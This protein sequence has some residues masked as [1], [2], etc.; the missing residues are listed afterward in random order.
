MIVGGAAREK[1]NETLTS[2]T[3]V[4]I[5]LLTCEE[6]S[7]RLS[8]HPRAEWSSGAIVKRPVSRLRRANVT[9]G[10][11]R[12]AEREESG[13]DH[14]TANGLAAE[15][16][17]SVTDMHRAGILSLSF[18]NTL[19]RRFLSWK[20]SFLKF[21]NASCK[22]WDKRRRKRH[23]VCGWGGVESG[24][25]PAFQKFMRVCAR[26]TLC[27]FGMPDQDPRHYGVALR[28]AASTDNSVLASSHLRH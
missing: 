21:C 23:A 2:P 10:Q 27:V 15:S 4:A 22:R 14:Q 5:I 13:R 6:C 19:S 7:L 11:A 1:R 20:P 24:Q 17:T 3:Q 28:R 26:K 8:D 9:M 12:L 18:S 25:F 16:P